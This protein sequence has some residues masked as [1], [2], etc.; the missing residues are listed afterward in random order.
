VTSRTVRHLSCAVVGG[1][2][3]LGCG[4]AGGT[5]G[6]IIEATEKTATPPAMTANEIT[7]FTD[8]VAGIPL[9]AVA[10]F[11]P[12]DTLAEQM[13]RA[14]SAIVGTITEVQLAPEQVHSMEQ[15]VCEADEGV[16]APGECFVETRSVDLA[17][18]VGIDARYERPGAGSLSGERMLT[19]QMPLTSLATPLDASR[20]RAQDLLAAGRAALLGHRT[21]WL[22]TAS[23]SG[24]R[25][26][27][28]A[29]LAVVAP[30]GSL[31]PAPFYASERERGIGEVE[32][33]DQLETRLLAGGAYTR[34]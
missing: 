22:L 23:S 31:V 20:A 3:M 7:D 32:S 1:L 8:F 28:N 15:V 26:T 34:R 14:G 25:L 27:D 4:S 33:L 29:S 30:G 16:P 21:A 9:F 12:A 19:V 6:A 11:P 24:L 13:Q 10:N 5:G 17:L 18:T 2:F